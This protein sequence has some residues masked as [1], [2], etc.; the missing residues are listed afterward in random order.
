[1]LDIRNA[2]DSNMVLLT[3]IKNQL[4]T[5]TDFSTLTISP[6]EEKAV[7]ELLDNGT[8]ENIV[9]QTLEAYTVDSRYDIR[10]ELI[11][12]ALALLAMNI[13]HIVAGIKC[14]YEFGKVIEQDILEK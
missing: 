4:E 11:V 2:Y 9:M 1:M 5:N 10:K 3:A 13:P 12:K 7:K 14:G 6:A 8:L